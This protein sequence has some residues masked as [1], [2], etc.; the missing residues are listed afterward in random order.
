MGLGDGDSLTGVGVLVLALAAFWLIVAVITA[1]MAAHRLRQARSVLLAVR[2][3][4]TLLAST[5]ARP[6]AVHPDGTVEIDAR[7]VREWG[8]ANSPSK[9]SDL[10]GEDRG[11]ATEDI[12]RLDELVRGAALSG[13][14]IQS[15]VHL[16]GSGR[17]ME[18]RGAPAQPRPGAE[19]LR[20][21]LRDQ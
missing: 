9:L 11:L 21:Q 14:S 2:A 10:A 5:P 18:V 1:V 8:F 6:M 15:Q 4:Q 16:A 3:M 7:L 13:G 17:V 12:N 19:Q 20:H